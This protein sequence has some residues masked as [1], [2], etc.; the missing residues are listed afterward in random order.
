M[1]GGTRKGAGRKAGT[2][3]YGEETR[4]LRVPVSLVTQVR[5]FLKGMQSLKSTDLEWGTVHPHLTAIA[6]PLYGTNVAAGFPSPADD[7]LDRMLDLNELLITNPAATFYV[8]VSGTSM[9]DAGIQP[10]DILLVDRSLTPK[11]NSIVIA[12]LNGELT[13]KRLSIGSEGIA[14]MPENP[15]Y[16]PIPIRE[17]MDFFV[18]GVVKNIIH[19]VA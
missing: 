14:L 11:H 6:L 3:T 9:V 4:P 12:A 16:T 17:E 10:G 1:R 13:V 19:T 2:G 5:S 15:T 8:R 7:H 18:W